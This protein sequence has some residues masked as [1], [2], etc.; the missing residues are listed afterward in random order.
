MGLEATTS[1][2]LGQPIRVGELSR[3]TGKSVRALHLYEEMG[4]LRPVHRTKGGFRLYAPSAVTRVE[5]ISRLQDA[6]FSLPQV[7]ELL[8]GVLQQ[9]HM[10]R[11]AMEEVRHRFEERL[12]ET[13]DQIKRLGALEI[14][15]RDS[16]EYLAGCMTCEPAYEPTECAGCNHNGHC[17]GE[18]PLLVAGLHRG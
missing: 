13:R 4:L 3:L 2:Q 15:L 8:A 10:S 16:L 11:T 7:Q 12:A 5:W 18:Q 1:G 6:G 9:A 14:E 17:D